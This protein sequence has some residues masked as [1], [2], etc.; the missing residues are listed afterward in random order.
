MIV[1]FY[2][3]EQNFFKINIYGI[4]DNFSSVISMIDTFKLLND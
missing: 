4:I 2:I 1:C 3:K